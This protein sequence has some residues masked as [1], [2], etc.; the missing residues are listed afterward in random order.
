MNILKPGDQI[1]VAFTI[2]RVQVVRFSNADPKGPPILERVTYDLIATGPN[3]PLAAPDGMID[4]D[5]PAIVP[6][7]RQPAP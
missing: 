7:T 2:R 5:S 4:A 1:A 3:G 6:L